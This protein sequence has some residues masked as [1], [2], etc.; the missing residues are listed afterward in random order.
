[1]IRIP[2]S[3]IA[4]ITLVLVVLMAATRFHHP[5]SSFTLADASLAVFFLAGLFLEGKVV[6]IGFLLEAF[7]ID[8][9]A[10]SV[11][12]VS[13][14]CVS[15]AYVFLI[16]TYTLLWWAGKLVSGF[17]VPGRKASLAKAALVL[18]AAATL[19][20]LISNLSFYLWSGRLAELVWPEY[21]ES[22]VREYPAYLGAVLFY[23]GLFMVGRL[24]LRQ[25]IA[26][27]PLDT[28]ETQRLAG[29]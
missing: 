24:L 26:S 2:S 28:G 15:P 22:L 27:R 25:W 7:L 18:M 5:G 11:G 21:V 16:P 4:W 3:S 12:G 9:S 17:A 14:F 19:A 13:G 6:L 23:T 1:M 20:F 29:H 10:I 8:Y